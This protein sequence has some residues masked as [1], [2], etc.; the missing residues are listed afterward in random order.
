MINHSAVRSQY[1]PLG[2]AGGGSLPPFSN[3]LREQICRL[4]LLSTIIDILLPGIYD[5]NAF[6]RRPEFSSAIVGR[7]A[8]QVGLT[9][10]IARKS[11]NSR[12]VSPEFCDFRAWFR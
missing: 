12:L 5:K 11:E 2:D 6:T 3:Y 8:R 4:Q 10:F 9:T 7:F 1:F